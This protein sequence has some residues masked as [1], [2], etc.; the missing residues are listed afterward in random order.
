MNPRRLTPSMSL[1]IAFEAAAR[2]GSFTKAADEL[3]LTQSAVSR[4]VQA[5]EAQLEVELFKRDGRRI[6]LTTAGAL[7]QHELAAALGRI[8]SATLQ[9][10]AHKAEGGTLHLAVLP[11]FGSKWLLPRMNDFY[12]RHPGYVV[13]V[14]SRIVHADLTPA[15]SEMNAII[16][17][18]TGNWP[19]YIAH[20]LVSEKLVL[21]ASPGALKGYAS[22]TPA[23]VAYY[24]L[25]SVVSRPNAWS[26]WF[27]RN[28]L[29]H[30][31]MRPGPS[32]E[33]TSHLIQAVAAGI[34]IALVPRILV[35]D[36][37]ASGELVTL[38]EPLDS[39]RNYYLAYAT[40]FQNLPSLCVFRDWLLSIPFPDSL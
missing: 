14:H 5:L 31:V 9:T 16:C 33:L 23:Q 15:A 39:G 30:H 21:I 24:S 12:A 22:M 26:D 17:A 35:L 34:G 2:H 37:L 27:E 28:R 11:T 32:F 19:G 7:Y 18:G 25:L 8:R 6:E 4:Q 20:P 1:L 40:R 38:F 36:E 3:T 29:D 10:I 13:H